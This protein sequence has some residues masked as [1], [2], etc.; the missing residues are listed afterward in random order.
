MAIKKVLLLPSSIEAL[1][2]RATQMLYSAIRER[3]N[4]RGISEHEFDERPDHVAEQDR[5][6][7]VAC[8]VLGAIERTGWNG[9]EDPTEVPFTPEAVDW[10]EEERQSL[11]EVD[12]QDSPLGHAVDA[13]LSEVGDLDGLEAEAIEELA[14]VA[15]RH[16][17]RLPERSERRPLLIRIANLQL[18]LDDGKVVA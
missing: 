15:Q 13:V 12:D 17:N 1:E 14:A 16:A 10:L 8:D 7:L 5:S 3:A 18:G 6:I 4:P 11:K 2:E 9:G